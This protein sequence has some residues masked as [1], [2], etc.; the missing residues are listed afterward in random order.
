MPAQ[1]PADGSIDRLP[2]AKVTS[3]VSQT[4]TTGVSLALAWDTVDEDKYGMWSAGA[5]T[6][7][8][9]PK[10]YSGLWMIEV[11]TPFA[12]STLGVRRLT[13]IVLG[14]TVIHSLTLPPVNAI[15]TASMAT[16]KRLVQGDAPFIQTFQ[17]TGGNLNIVNSGSIWHFA[18]T[19]LGH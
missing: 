14:V 4:M 2:Y 18:M 9:V 5:N 12:A 15:E 19:F 7:L 1:T 8:T 10:G 16:V 6:L 3:S 17:D 11:A 13:Q